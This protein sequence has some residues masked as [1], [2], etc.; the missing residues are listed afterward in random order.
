MFFVTF[1]SQNLLKAC[2]KAGVKQF[3]HTS[4][5][6][7]AY[8]HTGRSKP[9]HMADESVPFPKDYVS[10]YS[11]TKRLAENVRIPSSFVVVINIFTRLCFLVMEKRVY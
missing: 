9:I 1:S 11:Y 5:S 6:V 3:I 7:V 8:T 10:H 4:S 2:Q